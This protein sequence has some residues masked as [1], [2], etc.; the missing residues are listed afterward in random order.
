MSLTIEFDADN[1]NVFFPP[2]T[3]SMRGRYDAH[4]AAKRDKDAGAVIGSLPADVIPGLRL[5]IGDDGKVAVVEPLHLPEFKAIANRV[6]SRAMSLFPEQETV[7][8]D[9]PTALYWA[10]DAVDNGQAKIV[11]GKLPDKIEGKPRLS[12]VVTP[13]QPATQ[14]LTAAI[15]RQAAAFDRLA[16]VLEKA[17]AKR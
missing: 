6:A 17:L 2:L 14:T 1:R 9:L 13:Q 8:V 10:K 7:S 12:F 5:S 15:D 11:S 16:D 4:A 3:R